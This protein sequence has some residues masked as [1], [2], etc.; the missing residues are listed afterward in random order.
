MSFKILIKG[1]CTYDIFILI[2]LFDIT[3]LPTGQVFTFYFFI[4]MPSSFS[5]FQGAD[6]PTYLKKGGDSSWAVSSLL[7]FLYFFI[8]SFYFLRILLFLFFPFLDIP[9]SKKAGG[10]ILFGFSLVAITRGIWN[11]S[12]GTNKLK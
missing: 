6:D 11:M 8:S 7:C 3:F 2:S 12:H 1:T 4:L 5:F 10:A 9:Q